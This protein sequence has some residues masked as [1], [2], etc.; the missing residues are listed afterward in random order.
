MSPKAPRLPCVVLG[1]RL[2]TAALCGIYERIKDTDV[3]LQLV[4]ANVYLTFRSPLFGSE[5]SFLSIHFWLWF[6]CFRKWDWYSLALSCDVQRKLLHLQ[7][8]FCAAC[9]RHVQPICGNRRKIVFFFFLLVSSFRFLRYIPPSQIF[10]CEQFAIRRRASNNFQ[11][12][13]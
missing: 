4:P 13:T 6:N 5:V 9:I 2:I 3:Q 11:K 10:I 7:S 8:T 1:R 12:F